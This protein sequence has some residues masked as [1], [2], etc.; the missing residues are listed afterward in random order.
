[1]LCDFF[2]PHIFSL[3]TSQSAFI[4]F[5]LKW[6]CAAFGCHL[7]F[8][9]ISFG[10][11]F[12]INESFMASI[13]RGQKIGDFFCCC[14]RFRGKFAKWFK[15]THLILDFSPMDIGK[16]FRRSLSMCP[17]NCNAIKNII[18]L[19]SELTALVSFCTIEN[20]LK[21]CCNNL[22]ES[23]MLWSAAIKILQKIQ[24]VTKGNAVQ[25]K[26]NEQHLFTFEIWHELTC[27]TAV[28]CTFLLW[29]LKKKICSL[30]CLDFYFLF[31]SF[32]F[33]C[34]C[35]FNWVKMIHVSHVLMISMSAVF[36]WCESANTQIEC[37]MCCEHEAKVM[38]QKYVPSAHSHLTTW[39]DKRKPKIKREKRKICANENYHHCTN[40]VKFGSAIYWPFIPA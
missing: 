20:V 33:F 7:K 22:S 14:C 24:L 6:L 35:V 29:L 1:M 32:H 11:Y 25:L 36:V 18:H 12:R 17:L 16:D 15:I 28:H 34:V 19:N 38:N 5:F 23:K 13:Q 8:R 21:F 39:N 2:V 40:F 9:F 27:S 26:F 3:V 37:K 10:F 30:I 4:Y 31:I